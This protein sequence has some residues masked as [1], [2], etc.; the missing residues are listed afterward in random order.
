MASDGDVGNDAHDDR[1]DTALPGRLDAALRRI[2][3]PPGTR[4]GVLEGTTALH[5][6]L[7]RVAR[8][9][10]WTLVP[11]DPHDPTVAM[12]AH[13]RQTEVSWLVAGTSHARRWQD[14]DVPGVVLDGAGGVNATRGVDAAGTDAGSADIATPL[15]I[16]PARVILRTSGTTGAP[17]S[18]A[19][20][21][22]MLSAHATA[23]RERL[24]TGPDSVWLAC[25]PLHH[26]GGVTLVDRCLRGLGALRLAGPGSDAAVTAAL[27]GVTHVSLVPTQLARLLDRGVGP[28]DLRCA[29]LGGDRTTPALVRRAR[30]EGWPIHLTYGL[31]EACGQVA[32]ARPADADAAAESVG[33]P[34]P[35][36]EVRVGRA[37]HEPR[38]EL[39]TT[40][41][42]RGEGPLFVRGP[43]V[44]AEG[45]FDTGDIG[46]FDGAGRL[47]ITGRAA[48]RIVTG[49]ETVDAVAVED[50]L[51]THP[52]I[53]D[54]CV[55]GIPDK[56]WGQRVAAALVASAR[57]TLD[58]PSRPSD[59]A[60]TAWCKKRLARHAVPRIWRWIDAVP[61][62]TLGKPQR[63]AVASDL[64][65]SF[66]GREL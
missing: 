19:L 41:V 60:L 39:G 65:T 62:T 9:L 55:V 34:L 44:A 6:A 21:E 13:L 64:A 11:L 36:V 56:A 49:G 46:R 3:L 20:T 53:G 7:H 17:K 15:S 29:L 30:E 50:M 33:L 12:R 28:M 58:P 14:L 37:D 16:D 5:V 18:V 4:V 47:M 66:T 43:T 35:G 8:T 26:A 32:T 24:A 45:W 1:A 59:A 23:C 22:S 40:A 57:P 31:T 42:K 51:R 38:E 10:G 48:E 63:T 2:A 27:A 61:R 52:A 54:A 25:L